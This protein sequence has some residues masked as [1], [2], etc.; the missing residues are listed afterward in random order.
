MQPAVAD[1]VRRPGE[2]EHQ[3]MALDVL[4]IADGL[5]A[6]IVTFPPEVFPAFGLPPSCSAR[7]TSLAGLRLTPGPVQA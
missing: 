1:Y 2:E 6:E 7:R 4:R 5:V 3:P